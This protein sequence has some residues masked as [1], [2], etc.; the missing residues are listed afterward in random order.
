MNLEL[1]NIDSM[2]D[3]LSL[4]KDL[5]L[6]IYMYGSKVYGCN[7]KG[8]LD[9]IIVTSIKSKDKY[10][11]IS[12][13]DIDAT[14]YREDTFRE[15]I[16]KHNI[17][18]LE[19][20]FLSDDKILFKH[21]NFNFKLNLNSLRTSISQITSNSFVKTKKKLT[22]EK[23]YNPYIGKKSLFHSLRI[24][25]F[26]TQIAKYGKIIDYTEANYLWDEIVLN[27]SNDWNYYKENYQS[28]YNDLCSKF[29]EVAPKAIQ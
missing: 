18:V 7:P 21:K 1:L 27:E 5:V 28:V 23:D 19:C 4:S 29:R 6:N 14:I 9:L 26:G 13:N 20:L 3:K 25:M 12:I 2:L 17:A 22:V 16:E 11:Q 24:L 8:D 10:N 15:L